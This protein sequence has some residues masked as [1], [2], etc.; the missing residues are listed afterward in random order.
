[1]SVVHAVATVANAAKSSAGFSPTTYGRISANG[2]VAVGDDYEFSLGG[3]GINASCDVAIW[4]IQ[5]ATNCYIRVGINDNPSQTNTWYNTSG[6]S[7]GDPGNTSTTG[8]T[9]YELGEQCDSVK[10]N[11]TDVT[12]DGSPT[13]TN[14]PSGGT[15]TDNSAFSPTQ[16]T[17]YGREIQV[18]DT[19]SLG[20]T[21]QEGTVTFEV[22]F[23]KSGY[24]DLVVTFS[25]RAKA[26]SQ[27]E[28]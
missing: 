14:P 15:Y 25:I 10:I 18:L 23:I 5:T 17:K 13:F 12:V 11:H 24:T 6:V 20:A 27:W 26:L 28:P 3:P 7:Q 9:V 4:V 2:H 22:T 16:D 19:S 21:A 8:A 1:M